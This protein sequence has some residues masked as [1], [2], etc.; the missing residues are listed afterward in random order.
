M[1]RRWL[2]LAFIVTVLLCISVV[3]T[4][5]GD[6]LQSNE[7][8]QAQTRTRAQFWGAWQDLGI[9]G[10]MVECI[11]IDPT[12]S[13]IVYIGTHQGD[14]IFKSTDGGQTW[15][16]IGTPEFW[17]GHVTSGV[18]DPGN[19]NIIY[20][21]HGMG[22]FKSTDSGAN[23][24]LTPSPPHDICALAIDPTNGQTLYAASGLGRH[25]PTNIYKTNNGGMSW[26]LLS[27]FP[28]IHNNRINAIA[29][30]PTLPN[31][32]LAVSGYFPTPLR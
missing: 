28:T 32:I 15:N 13:N 30:H 29:V 10:G 22:V 18:I 19:A 14:K 1:T 20:V 2:Y 24:S 9:H 21:G 11:T 4:A 5:N 12:N 17:Y 3:S 16:A 6:V 23:W 7:Q 31:I 26:T 8:A 27:G 25:N